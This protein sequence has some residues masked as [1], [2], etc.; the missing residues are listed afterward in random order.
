VNLA[1][2]MGIVAWQ[3]LDALRSDQITPTINI[4]TSEVWCLAQDLDVFWQ[5]EQDER[6]RLLVAIVQALNLTVDAL[7]PLDNA[8]DY[9]GEGLM[10]SFGVAHDAALNLPSLEAMLRQ[11][12]LK[13]QAWQ[14]CCQ[15]LRQ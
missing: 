8:D 11:P 1:E 3:R 4:S 15:Y 2:V 9:V 13:R 14:T 7:L 10:L 5:D 12:L 6:W